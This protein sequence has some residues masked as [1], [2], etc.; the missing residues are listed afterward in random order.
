MDF[1]KIKPAVEEIAL[2]NEQTEQIINSCKGKKRKFNYKPL[3]AAAAAAIIIVVIAS[4][5]F[6]FRAKEAD[7]AVAENAKQNPAEDYYY[8]ADED[9]YYNSSASGS[10]DNAF[11]NICEF[12]DLTAFEA[13][14]FNE[15]Y[16]LIPSEFLYLS[17]DEDLAGWLAEISADDGMAIMQ[18]V[19]RFNVS[20]ED[21]DHS[22]IGFAAR[23]GK[24]FD[25]DAIY[26]FDK[27][28]V[29]SIYR[30]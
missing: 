26:T 30:K 23:T 7:N 16:A 25:S 18:F 10:G 24:S 3:I 15:L 13:E 5:G 19:I 9:I 12:I 11:Q 27:E 22:N 21:F 29:D 8:I 20:K 17:G 2:T 6:L 14:E 1:S 28:L 4:P